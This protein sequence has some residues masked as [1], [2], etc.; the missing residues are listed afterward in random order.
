MMEIGY[1]AFVYAYYW[2]TKTMVDDFIPSFSRESMMELVVHIYAIYLYIE[3]EQMFAGYGFHSIEYIL[4]I[5][6]SSPEFTHM[7]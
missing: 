3:H 5:V 4:K 1:R 2:W 6:E 7:K